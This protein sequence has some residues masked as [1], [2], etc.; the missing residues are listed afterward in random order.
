M[1]EPPVAV[2]YIAI[3][4]QWIVRYPDTGGY[5]NYYRRQQDAWNVAKRY[6]RK[7]RGVAE[8]FLKNGQDVRCT[9]DYRTR[10]EKIQTS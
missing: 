4:K 2:Y 5:H 3:F 7:R 1:T 8:L 10:D 6:A 9:V